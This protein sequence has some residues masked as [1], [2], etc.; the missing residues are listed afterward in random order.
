MMDS[1]VSGEELMPHRSAPGMCSTS[2]QAEPPDG[3]SQS[4]AP[5]TPIRKLTRNRGLIIQEETVVEDTPE[6]DPSGEPPPRCKGRQL[7][8]GP[9]QYTCMSPLFHFIS[10][11]I[12]TYVHWFSFVHILVKRAPRMVSVYPIS[13]YHKPICHIILF[14]FSSATLLHGS[15]VD[16]VES[17]QIHF[18]KRCHA[19]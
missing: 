3:D 18:L 10:Y 4:A 5:S 17:C 8:A 13:H 16:T 1:V 9:W 19:V 7:W 12:L 14:L 2:L 11:F 15:S 6:K